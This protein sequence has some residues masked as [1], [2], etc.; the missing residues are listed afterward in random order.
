LFT[1]Q[2]SHVWIDF[3]DIQDAFMRD[4]GI[5]YFENSRR[6]TYVQQQGKSRCEILLHGKR[7][8]ILLGILRNKARHPKVIPMSVI[9]LHDWRSARSGR[10]PTSARQSANVLNAERKAEVVIASFDNPQT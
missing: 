3:R 6:A 2:L 1:H 8:H 7:K 5:D 10:H 9:G 4:K